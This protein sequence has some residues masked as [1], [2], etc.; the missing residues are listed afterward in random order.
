M[1][2]FITFMQNNWATIA[3]ILIA[4]IYLVIK[5]TPDDNPRWG[6]VD[7]VLG[8]LADILRDKS[9]IKDNI[10]NKSLS[11]KEIKAFSRIDSDETLKQKVKE[12]LNSKIKTK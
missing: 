8:F 6:I 4:L 9:K 7:I 1:E 5:I 11:H 3:P 2:I 12:F 10:S